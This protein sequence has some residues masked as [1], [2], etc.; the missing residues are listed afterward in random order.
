MVRVYTI[1]STDFDVVITG[2]D[3]PVQTVSLLRVFMS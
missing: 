2:D 1:R 3:L